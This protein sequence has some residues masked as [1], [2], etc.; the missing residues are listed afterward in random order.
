MLQAFVALALEK[1]KETFYFQL[2]TS[3]CHSSGVLE[4]LL[5]LALSFCLSITTLCLLLL[6]QLVARL[7]EFW[8]LELSDSAPHY[9][10]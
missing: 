1:A 5:I 7:S 2:K 6:A 8:S 3:Q 10:L 9:F 4:L